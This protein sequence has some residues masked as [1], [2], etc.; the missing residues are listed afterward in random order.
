MLPNLSKLAKLYLEDRAQRPLLIELS[1]L[2][3]DYG[4]ASDPS[5]LDGICEIAI[6]GILTASERWWGTSYGDIQERMQRAID[7]PNCKGI[8]LVIDSP[9]GDTDGCPEC[10]SFIA[11]AAKKKP[12]WAICDV[13]AY[14]AACWLASAAS[15]VYAAPESGG[16]GSIGVYCAHVDYSKMLDKEGINVTL[17]SAGTGKTDG[18]PYEPL[19][20]SAKADIQAEIDRRYSSFVE[21]IAR[22]RSMSPEKVREMGAKLFN[23]GK[24]AIASG[25]ADAIATYDQAM[26]D[27]SAYLNSQQSQSSASAASA[28]ANPTPGEPMADNRA[29]ATQAAT[30]PPPQ[31]PPVT[32]PAQPAAA[33]ISFTADSAR[34]IEQLCA[35][36]GQPQM[37]ACLIVEGLAGTP[38]ATIRQRIIDARAAAAGSEIQSRVAPGAGT[39]AAKAAN[40]D[41]SPLMRAT[42][43]LGKGGF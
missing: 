10:A 25:L 15:K 21:A 9:G 5:N 11:A 19:S 2:G 31:T 24:M 28:V 20:K 13:N 33:A 4:Q 30:T 32:A 43:N 26:T 6:S 16:I 7:D 36:A 23:G 8:A 22:G 39:D 1:A 3:G 42:L 37:A 29:D 35:I 34:E 12:V 38:L 14:S 27:F 40:P 18:N 41:D 17:I